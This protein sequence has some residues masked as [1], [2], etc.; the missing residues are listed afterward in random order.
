MTVEFASH[1]EATSVEPDSRDPT[2]NPTVFR[3][4]LREAAPAL[5]EGLS[6]LSAGAP[7]S[8]EACFA[9]P[10][11]LAIIDP[12]DAALIAALGQATGPAR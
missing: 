10:V 4:L 9:A 5:S 7:F 2:M 1:P 11:V 8:A 12:P 3:Q 6:R